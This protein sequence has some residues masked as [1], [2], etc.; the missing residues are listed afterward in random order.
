MKWA[1][2][3]PLICPLASVNALDMGYG[4][5]NRLN[6]LEAFYRAPMNSR[7][8]NYRLW[9]G[10]GGFWSVYTLSV[11][12][13]W[14]SDSLT[15]KRVLYFIKLTSFDTLLPYTTNIGQKID[16]VLSD[17]CL[18]VHIKSANMVSVEHRFHKIRKNKCSSKKGVPIYENNKFGW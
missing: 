11:L 9:C 16:G 10:V 1:S 6:A 14:F 5:G 3:F 8:A 18:N 13:W 2:N 4:R 15:L 7:Q 12:R 17:K